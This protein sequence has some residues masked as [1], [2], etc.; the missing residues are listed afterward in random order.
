MRRVF[1]IALL[2]L[3][4]A[5][6]I[7]ALNTNSFAPA[8]AG[9][10]QLL[11]HRGLGQTFSREGLT[12]T[13]CTAARLLPVEHP[14]IEN[15]LPSFRAAFAAGASIVEF[16][17][18]PTKDGH[19]VVFHDWTLDCRTNGAG[20]TRDQDLASLKALDVGHGY[21]ADGGST[22]P[23]RHQG[24]GQMP[25]LDEVLAAFP[26]G[27]FLINIKS[28]DPA[29]GRQLASALARVPA[30]ARA[31]LMVYGA[32][33]PVGAFRASLPD[34]R[35]FTTDA[36][37]QC[38]VRYLALGWSGYVPAACR[39]TLFF[40]P[41]NYTPWTWG[42][43]H[44]LA[45]RLRAHNTQIMLLGPYDGS[46]FS[47]G[48]DDADTFARVPQDFDGLVWTNRIDRIGKPTR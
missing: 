19:F 2:L 24:I 36:V 40:V 41:V 42:F 48:I 34:I 6:G 35:A 25:T 14:Y 16:D 11:A 38:F 7:F 28:N 18:Q 13:T 3:A 12:G 20:R 44:R 47:S 45:A 30:A 22:F 8:P 27:R 43:P 39:D 10:K 37:K 21:T 31:R 9:P 29:E 26:D 17:V 15:T 4:L 5:A 32:A 23:F 33:A 46:G 1:R